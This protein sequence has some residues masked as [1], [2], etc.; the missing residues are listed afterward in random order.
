MT[1]ASSPD[2]YH[3]LGLA[4]IVPF[5]FQNFTAGSYSWVFISPDKL[6]ISLVL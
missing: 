2:V 1:A 3:L 6:E 5:V 4:T